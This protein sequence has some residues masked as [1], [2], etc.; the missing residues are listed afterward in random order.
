MSYLF[1]PESYAART[2]NLKSVGRL[3]VSFDEHGKP[4]CFISDDKWDFRYYVLGEIKTVKI[5]VSDITIP[6]REAFYTT[7]LASDADYRL[8][9][10]STILNKIKNL[11]RVVSFHPKKDISTWSGK[12]DLLRLLEA[13][14]GN[15]H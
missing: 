5:D 7:Y 15:R 4:T 6:T 11:K 13:I 12:K 10:V 14:K 1:H 3:P 8:S 9:K 2:S